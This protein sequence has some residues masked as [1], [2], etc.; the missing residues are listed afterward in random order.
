MWIEIG[1][2]DPS[3]NCPP[4]DIMVIPLP[5]NWG[6]GSQRNHPV[7]QVS[8][9]NSESF[10]LSAGLIK[11]KKDPESPNPDFVQLSLYRYLFSLSPWDTI[12]LSP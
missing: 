4:K 12:F 1:F 6:H 7:D 8:Q 5:Q 3:P 2:G 9:G 11:K 10:L